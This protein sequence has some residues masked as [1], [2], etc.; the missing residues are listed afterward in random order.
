MGA[1]Q[2]WTPTLALASQIMD[3]VRD[4]VTVRDEVY[5]FKYFDVRDLLGFVDGT[6]NP[7]GPVASAA[8]LIGAED[9]LFVGGSYVIVQKYLH[10]PQ[11]WNALPVEAQE[12]VI[13]RT[14]LSDIELDNTVKPA[15]SHVALTTIVDPDGTQR[16][17]LRDNMPFGAVGRGEFGTYFIGYARTPAVTERMLE[18]CSSAIRRPATTGSWTFHPG[19]RHPV[20]RTQCRF[21]RRPTR[22]AR[23]RGCEYLMPPAHRPTR[24]AEPH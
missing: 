5:G 15:D 23:H 13:G 22:F 16:Q 19:D 2:R 9:P 11:A 17:I 1:F 8:V 6:E 12:K 4:V 18:R 3:R 24:Q 14:K 21:P 20:L 10:D 7:I